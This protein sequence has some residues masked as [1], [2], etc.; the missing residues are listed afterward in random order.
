MR[1][2]VVL[3]DGTVLTVDSVVLAVGHLDARLNAEQRELLSAAEE[4]G[5]LYVPPAAPADVDW[6][7]GA[8]RQTCPGARHGP[9]LL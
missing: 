1:F 5:L 7:R 2:D 4:L 3:D 6:S 8:G 9:E